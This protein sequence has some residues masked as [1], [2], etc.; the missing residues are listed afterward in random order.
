MTETMFI[1]KGVP[2]LWALHY[3]IGVMKSSQ[4]KALRFDLKL[5]HKVLILVTVPILFMLVFVGTLAGLQKRAE[6][7]VWRERHYKDVSNECNSLMKN[8]LEAGMTLHLYQTTREAA[9]LSRFDSTTETV[10]NQLRT[11][12]VMSQDSSKQKSFLTQLEVASDRALKALKHARTVGSGGL[13]APSGSID[14]ALD[15][16]ATLRQLIN[17]QQEADPGAQT[18]EQARFLISQLLIAG[19]TFS[20]LLAVVLAVLFNRSTTRRLLVLVQNTERLSS[21]KELLPAVEGNDEIA[22]LDH[23]FH[24]MAKSLDEAA[25]YKKELLAIVTHDLRSPL[26]SVQGSLTLLSVGALGQLPEKAMGVVVLAE[27]NV[28]RLVSLINDMLDIEKL[29]SGKLEVFPKTVV[30]EELLE[31]ARE[32]VEDMAKKKEITIEIVETELVMSLDDDRIAQVLINLLSN[33]IKF[34]PEQSNITLSSDKIGDQA[35]YRVTDMGRGVPKEFVETIFER[36]VQVKGE[37]SA[38]GRGT[39]LGLSICKKFV[40]A[41]GGTIGVTSEEGQGSTF[42][43]RLPIETQVDSLTHER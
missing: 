27:R 28:G 22:H 11:L 32:A 43:F 40:E 38:R 24:D 17:E 3:R 23:V 9:L 39:G 5:S 4:L 37:D 33:A 1:S 34:S 18:E 8:M 12:K 42:W 14:S 36:Y 26:T 35:E 29:E 25:E 6:E 13:S 7:A 21:H 16:F 31:R 41:H 15:A 2:L 19:V 10:V 20:I 30:V